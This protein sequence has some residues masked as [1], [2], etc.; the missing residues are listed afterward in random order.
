MK[1]TS[2]SISRARSSHR[3]GWLTLFGALLLAPA[4][5][6]A[7]TVYGESAMVKVRPSAPPRAEAGVEL[8]AARN[9]FVSFQ[10]VVH[11]GESGARDV[12]ALFEG[13][14]GPTSIG[15]NQTTLYRAG[16]LNITRSSGKLGETGPWPDPLIPDVD[17]LTGERRQAFPFDV[18]AGEARALWADVLVPENA[19][20]GIYQGTV[21]VSG[22]GFTTDVPVRLRVVDAT[23]P[24][25]SSLASAFLIS[26][27]QTC[28]AHTGRSDCG[29]LRQRMDLIAR[30]ERMALEH[31]LTLSNAFVPPQGNDWSTFDGEYAPFLEGTADT[32]LKG[33]RMTS[34]Q[35]TG[36]REPA[37]LAAFTEH[38]RARGWLERA[39]DYTG[40]EPPYGLSFAE[41]VNRARTVRQAAPG[42]RTLLTTH[43][44]AAEQHGL[45]ELIDVMTP[46]VN[47]LDGT[48]SPFIGSQRDRYEAYLRRP[49]K[50]LWVYQSCMSHGCS[51]GTN[52][53]E[54]QQDSGWPSYMVDRSAAKNRAMQ[55]V[56]FA[57]RASG[58]LY[59]QTTEALTTAWKD[60]F[61]YNGNGDGT[62]FYPGT[63][64]AI[65]GTT[66]IPVAS[67]RLK[68][69][70]QGMQDYEWLKLVSDAGDPDFAHAVARELIPAAHKVGDDGEAFESARLRLIA[71][72]LE[73]ARKPALPGIS[74]ED[75][76]ASLGKGDHPPALSSSRDDALDPTQE[77]GG[78][79]GSATG[80]GPVL[81]GLLGVALLPWRKRR[82]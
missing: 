60:V 79:G 58:E 63:A 71:R 52:A 29:G 72:Y 45:D 56:A 30:Y 19:P 65:G 36:K 80:L 13:L 49:N 44:A 38:M 24:S 50:Q 75:A 40:D 5:W 37:R 7:P 73:L 77:P 42:L 48:K 53:P 82:R 55:W 66:P 4:A 62:L 70:R 54:N 23:L 1:Q 34:A 2:N 61:R 68:H 67:I 6:A 14:N 32:R 20:P 21:Q 81:L 76:D 27:M 18:P 8:V 9:E 51:F 12:G 43:I 10:V 78:C 35:F 47:H 15:G 17:E 3:A 11:G 26:S 41:A 16:Y 64:A 57:E 59:Y 25:T 39:Y 31:R 28:T 74:P 33:A 69:I 46:V 22:Q